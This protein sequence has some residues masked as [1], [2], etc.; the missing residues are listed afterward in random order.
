MSDRRQAA[1][2]RVGWA[3]QAYQRATQAFDDEVR[4]HLG[5]NGA[6]LRCLD[7]LA[8][9]P[10]SP[11]ELGAA[12]GLSSAAT[13]AMLDRLEQRG[14]V[15]RS[16][17]PDD[18]RRV[19][20]AMTA[21]A[22][23]RVGELYGPLAAEGPT[24]MADLSESDLEHLADLLDQMRNVTERHREVLHAEELGKAAAEQE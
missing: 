7:W 1:M 12:T 22:Q 3:L 23:R 13:T 5:V 20:V 24:L 17:D 9:R 21:E 18:R 10:R 8:D 14:L 2:G 15:H 11:R 6:D 16:P 19:V 4:R